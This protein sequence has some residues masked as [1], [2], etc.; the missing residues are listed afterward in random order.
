[1][2]LIHVT[3][4]VDV[5]TV[6]DTY[7][8]SLDAEQPRVVFGGHIYLIVGKPNA[9]FGDGSQVLV[10]I[11]Q[12]GDEICWKA[13]SSTLASEYTVA[14][15]H[16]GI[17]PGN[18]V[19]GQAQFNLATVRSFY[20]TTTNHLAFEA[21]DVSVPY[22]SAKASHAGLALYG[23]RFAVLDGAGGVRGFYGWGGS[24]AVRKV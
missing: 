14:L 16:F 11:A 2:G 17:N 15:Y 13:I 22:W 21:Q 8:G 10:L 3:I 20:P 5:E 12:V 23:F 9:L 6:L 1:M 19:L 7:P 18:P 4:V 24:V